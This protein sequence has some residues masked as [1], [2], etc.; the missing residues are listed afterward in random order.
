MSD[1]KSGSRL[2][3]S[4]FSLFAAVGKIKSRIKLMGL[5]GSRTSE[6]LAGKRQKR[7][8]KSADLFCPSMTQLYN[9]SR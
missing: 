3:A 7:A 1:P 9:P 6:P 8:K 4:R 5:L 2:H